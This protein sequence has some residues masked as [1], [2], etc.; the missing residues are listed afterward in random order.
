MQR[1][2][3]A[4]QSGYMFIEPVMSHDVTE[5]PRQHTVYKNT[6]TGKCTTPQ[7]VQPTHMYMYDQDNCLYKYNVYT[8]LLNLY[9]CQ[10][11]NQ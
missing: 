11:L 5:G 1:G 8:L 6:E 2:V 3:I 10:I 7:G 4:T 9:F